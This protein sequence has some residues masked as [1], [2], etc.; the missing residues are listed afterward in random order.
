MN[1]SIRFRINTPT[2]VHETIDGEVVIINLQDGNYYSLEDVGA[3]IWGSIDRGAS[4]GEIIGELDTDY[5][6]NRAQIKSAVEQFLVELKQGALIVPD[7]IEANGSVH[8]LRTQVDAEKL[9]FEAPVLNRYTDMQDLLLL[10]PIHD[11][12]EAGWPNVPQEMADS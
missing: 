2:V 1:S 3:N 5:T 11:V 10:D 12:D 8:A 7:E 9:Q 6:A 4:V